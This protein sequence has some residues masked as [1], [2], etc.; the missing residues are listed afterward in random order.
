M[1]FHADYE[2][3]FKKKTECEIEVGDLV[4]IRDYDWLSRDVA[5]VTEVRELIHDQSNKSYYAVTATLNGKE[6]TF[7]HRDFELISKAERK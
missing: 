7:S 4:K 6:Y 5:L 2:E 1:V 3:V